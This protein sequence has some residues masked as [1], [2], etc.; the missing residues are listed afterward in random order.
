MNKQPRPGIS[1]ILTVLL[2]LMATTICPV[3]TARFG[4]AK[5]IGG[6]RN[7]AGNVAN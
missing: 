4:G 5:S 6:T 7:D 1:T 3:T 2:V